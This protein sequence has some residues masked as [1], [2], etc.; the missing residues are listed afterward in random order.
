[1]GTMKTWTLGSFRPRKLT[2]IESTVEILTEALQELTTLIEPGFVTSSRQYIMEP[3]FNLIMDVA[4]GFE[5]YS[6]LQLLEHVMLLLQCNIKYRV[7]R[8]TL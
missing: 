7:K 2:E 5:S 3:L 8:Y 6:L 1:M 4:L